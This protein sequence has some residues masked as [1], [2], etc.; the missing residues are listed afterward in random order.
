MGFVNLTPHAITYRF[1]V[2][3]LVFE[4]FFVPMRL[5]EVDGEPFYHGMIKMTP[6]HF[7]IQDLPEI[8]VGDIYIV[9]AMVLAEVKK[10]GRLDF[11]APDTGS[12]AIRNEK[13]QI[14]A[15]TGFIF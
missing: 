9:S 4:P 2:E 13:G 5:K 3:E 15:V 10:L 7:V 1:G 11:V 6:R 12:G 8:V 14:V